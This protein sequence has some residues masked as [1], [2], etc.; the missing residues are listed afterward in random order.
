MDISSE[1]TVTEYIFKVYC[2]PGTVLVAEDV[3]E[4]KTDKIPVLMGKTDN[5]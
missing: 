5:K 1:H 3:T 2:V 4:N